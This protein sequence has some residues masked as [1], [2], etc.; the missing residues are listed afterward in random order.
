MSAI[1]DAAAEWLLRMSQPQP[2]TRERQA[3]EAW[4]RADVRHQGAYLRVLAVDH[5]LGRILVQH[6]LRP[7]PSRSLSGNG[8]GRRR[9]LRYGGGLAA[10]LVLGAGAW[11][12]AHPDPTPWPLSLATA[13]GELRAVALADHSTVSLNSASRVEVVLAAHERRVDLVRGEAWFAVAK[14]RSKPFTV[15]AGPVTV[16]AL[17]TAFSVRRWRRGV[18]ILV[19]EGTVET[20][21]GAG[22]GPRQLLNAGERGFVPHRRAR[23]DVTRAPAEVARKLAWRTGKLV[24]VNQTLAEAVADFNRYST[25]QIIVTDP[26]LRQFTFMGQYPLDAAERFAAD[27]S[28][29][30]GVPL[31]VTAHTIEIGRA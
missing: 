2:T 26:A 22:T 13:K 16:R 18:E 21:N 29:Y 28:A 1:D 8:A 10:G 19:T 6:D 3:F 31:R 5:A 15:A 4:C 7:Q 20:W 23:I 24:F 27:I 11:R 30:L 17:G 12:F 9:L 14:D 25:R